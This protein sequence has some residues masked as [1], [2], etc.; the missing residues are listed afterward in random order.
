V[1]PARLA[2]AFV[3]AV[4]LVGCGGND[5]DIAA[6]EQPEATA[7]APD[8]ESCEA[9]EPN[10]L[11]PQ[12]IS[13][14]LSVK[15][16]VPAADQPPP[17]GLVTADV[18]VGSGVEATVGTQALVKYVGAF[19]ESGEEFDSSWSRGADETLPVKLG[20]MMVI[21]GFDQGIAGM[22]VGGRRYVV[23]PPE[24][25]YGPEGQGPIP[26]NATLV[27]VIDLVEVN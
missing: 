16:E 27:F 26:P 5:D 9:R 20:G 14:D 1:R 19:Y 24:L 17:C 11:P 8:E 18:V 10:P 2:T 23:I 7:A 12:E 21:P 4:A 3:L 22:K 13:R 15:P 6:P 25:G